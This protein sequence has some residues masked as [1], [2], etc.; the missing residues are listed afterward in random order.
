MRRRAHRE[1][2]G[3]FLLCKLTLPQKRA[4]SGD[5][6]KS[7]SETEHF[8]KKNC[9]KLASYVSIDDIVLDQV[10]VLHVTAES[11]SWQVLTG[12]P[13]IKI[14]YSHPIF[15]FIAVPRALT[16]RL[17]INLPLMTIPK[18]AL[19]GC[20]GRFL[21]QFLALNNISPNLLP[22]HTSLQKVYN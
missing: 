20:Q 3:L 15:S 11:P 21:S 8:Q 1:H 6:K 18:E 9:S 4:L 7:R 22:D 5:P 2:T 10:H 14:F 13:L 17:W 16:L 12:H 19:E